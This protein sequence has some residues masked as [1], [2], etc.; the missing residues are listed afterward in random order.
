MNATERAR[1]PQ[2][3]RRRAPKSKTSGRSKRQKPPSP[4]LSGRRNILVLGR[5]ELA[6]RITRSVRE[7]G[8]PCRRLHTPDEALGSVDEMTKAMVV[9]PP[10]PNL[11]VAAFARSLDAE[12]SRIPIF[13]V[14]EG[15][16]P[17]R[18]VRKLYADGIEAVFEWPTDRQA[19]KR[20]L[21]RVAAPT[22][23]RWGRAKSASEIALEETARTHLEAEAVP[24]GA[25]LSVEA[26]RRF[27]VLKGSLDALWKLELARQ[28]VADIPGVEDVLADGVEIAGQ[29]HDDRATA[30]AIREVLKHAARV[31][32]STLAIAVRSGEVTVTGSVRD[33]R[34]ATRALELIRQVRGVRRVQNF[35]VISAR[36]KKQDAALAKRVREVL[37]TRYPNL[38]VD[39]SV[40]GNVAVLSGR[41]P[42][43]GVRDKIKELVYGQDGVERVVDKLSVSG[44]ARR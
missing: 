27:L 6:K 23:G 3:R 12:P 31:E 24:F 5:S 30:R 35:L 18:T 37:R 25:H 13:A 9:V 39:L 7:L 36:G 40:F 20:T 10:I 11:S 19:F 14:M 32:K 17:A 16:M 1:K 26:C 34:E 21:F 28:I 42:R 4:K 38:Q 15:P 43:A 22:I 2:P 41:V 33:K 44:R 29:S 8:I